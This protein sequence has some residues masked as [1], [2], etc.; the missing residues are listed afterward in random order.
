[1]CLDIFADLTSNGTRENWTQIRNRKTVNV[2][3]YK[4]PGPNK[5]QRVN[6]LWEW[7]PVS[8]DNII[9]S[10]MQLWEFR[11]I[12]FLQSRSPGQGSL[13]FA[14]AGVASLVAA[15][16]F[17]GFRMRRSSAPEYADR[18]IGSQE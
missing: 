6:Q 10:T 1:M 14:V 3:I 18:M 17:M 2:Q 15:G 8:G 9:N 4:C 7:A 13:A 11:D 16:F 12:G 5:T